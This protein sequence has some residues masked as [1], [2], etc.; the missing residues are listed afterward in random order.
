MK[1][2]VSKNTDLKLSYNTSKSKFSK[3]KMTLKPQA[4]CAIKQTPRFFYQKIITI[5]RLGNK[6]SLKSISSLKTVAL[7]NELH[8]NVLQTIILGFVHISY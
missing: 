6:N 3:L 5:L 1:E 4:Y 2:Y 8:I 7:K